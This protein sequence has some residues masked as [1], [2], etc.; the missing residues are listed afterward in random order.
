MAIKRAV[1]QQAVRMMWQMLCVTHQRGI[2]RAPMIGSGSAANTAWPSEA[3]SQPAASESA[4]ALQPSRRAAEW[5]A[6]A[7]QRHPTAAASSM[8]AHQWDA[9]QAA[10][11][12]S[13]D[14]ST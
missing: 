8:D 11:T 13:C 4:V 6:N 2:N 12:C 7:G 9:H 10:L 14:P 5:P 1:A 3:C